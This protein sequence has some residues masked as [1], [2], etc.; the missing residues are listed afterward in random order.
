MLTADR[1]LFVFCRSCSFS[2]L[3]SA[4]DSNKKQDLWW[5]FSVVWGGDSLGE[6]AG[7]ILETAQGGRF[8]CPAM[9]GVAGS[10]Q[11]VQQLDVAEPE[12]PPASEIQSPASFLS[13]H[14]THLHDGSLDGKSAEKGKRMQPVS[15]SRGF[16][17]VSVGVEERNL[18]AEQFRVRWGL[19][20]TPSQAGWSKGGDHTRLLVALH[21]GP[22]TL[23]QKRC[24][25]QHHACRRA[26]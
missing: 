3:N 23:L 20:L 17:C 26:W 18:S 13:I 14:T 25:S 1:H 19:I 16:C 15:Q 6:T 10:A 2:S 21:R 24:Q 5:C 4:Q 9:A 12:M 22:V 8:S 11:Q 7:A